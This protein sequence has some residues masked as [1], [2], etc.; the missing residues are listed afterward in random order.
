MPG[1][2][3]DSLPR[4][5][6]AL[7]LV[8]Y[9]GLQQPQPEE[10]GSLGCALPARDSILGILEA[11]NLG[12]NDTDGNIYYPLNSAASAIVLLQGTCLFFFFLPALSHSSSQCLLNKLFFPREPS[13]VN[14][15][16]GSRRV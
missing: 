2:G 1:E 10:P 11:F 12:M 6:G 9:P 7:T 8:P 4:S 15:G 13:T 5:P 3:T 14:L 16:L